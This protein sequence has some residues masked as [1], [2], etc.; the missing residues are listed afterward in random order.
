M[1]TDG[2]SVRRQLRSVAGITAPWSSRNFI[3]GTRLTELR[4][5]HCL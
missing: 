2:R 1:G 5:Q 4:E 3:C